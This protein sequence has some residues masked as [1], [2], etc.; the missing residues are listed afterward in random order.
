MT[1]I[2][3]YYWYK[4]YEEKIEAFFI[5]CFEEWFKEYISKLPYIKDIGEC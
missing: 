2:E 4:E 1:T 5:E 3:K